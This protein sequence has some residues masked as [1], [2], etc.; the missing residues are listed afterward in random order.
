MA[1]P[2]GAAWVRIAQ[3]VAP[4]LPGT[5]VRRGGR[6]VKAALIR[7]PY[8][9]AF[10]WVGLDRVRVGDNPYLMA[11]V[12]ALLDGDPGFA[13]SYGLRSDEVPHRPPT[14]NM[15][16]K[17]AAD[18]VRQFI[19]EDALP[20][21]GPGTDEAL[22]AATEESYL[23][24]RADHVAAMVRRRVGGWSTVPAR[25][26]SPLERPSTVYTGSTLRS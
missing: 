23:E 26:W 13:A 17:D 20:R 14:V 24:G 25:P 12:V 4:T 2:T 7:E 15:L 5:W 8:A 19:V 10:T 3:E 1:D 21:I 16:A 9:W 18:R 6:G 11:G 22:A